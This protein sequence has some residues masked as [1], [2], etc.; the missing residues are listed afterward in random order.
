MGVTAA[1]AGVA[2]AGSGILSGIL[3]GNASSK[4]AS[5]QAAAQQ[6]A[7]QFQQGVYNTEQ[8]NLNPF[9][10][11]GTSALGSVAQ[12][13]GLQVPGA[14]AG[15]PGAGGNALQAYQAYQKTPFY[16]FPLQQ[17]TQTLQ[18]SGAARGLTLSGGQANA[19]QAYGQGYAGSNFGNY[20]SGLTSLAGLGATSATSLGSFGNT[21]A[22]TTAGIL[23]NQGNALA[24]GTAG[25]ATGI[26][27]ALSNVGP[28]LNAG[29]NAF[30]NNSSYGDQGWGGATPSTPGNL[31]NYG[32]TP[33]SYNASGAPIQFS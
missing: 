15:S 33:A 28:L 22:G 30:G 12:L 26:N 1:V 18:N 4:A 13:Y 31:I 7:L 14:T 23:N 2:S 19:L 5:Q 20:I 11:T 24:A 21:A 27:N 25:Q 17:G 29:A 8:T 16:Q 10:Q 3:G 9:I 6:Q 32:A